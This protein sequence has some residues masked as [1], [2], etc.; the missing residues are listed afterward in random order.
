MAYSRTNQM[1]SAADRSNR[2]NVGDWE[3]YAS[4][5]VGL[6]FLGAALR[7]AY[8][9][10]SSGSSASLGLALLGRGLGGYCPVYGTLGR[11]TATP[12]RVNTS[13]EGVDV[14]ESIII[15][16]PVEEVYAAWRDLEHLPRFMQHLERVDVI[17]DRR[18]HWVVKGPAGTTLEWDAEIVNDIPN[19]LLAWE[20]M[21]GAD[22]VSSGSVGFHSVDEG[23]ST[24][25]SV[26]LQYEPPAGRVGALTAWLLGQEPSLQVPED[27]KRLK[28]ALEE[29]PR[30]PL[31]TPTAEPAGL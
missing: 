6:L 19:R 14:R 7:N 8:R 2:C 25:V 9:G 12:T 16:R 13:A 20:S 3:R 11:N 28:R 26:G 15:D 17:D 23:R 10:K 1:E 31:S 21:A 30:L 22:I 5:A 27:L 4:V 29:A 18:S 24:A